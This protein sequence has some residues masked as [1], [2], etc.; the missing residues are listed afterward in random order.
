[1]YLTTSDILICFICF[2]LKRHR[3]FT[4]L[5]KLSVFLKYACFEQDE[6]AVFHVYLLRLLFL[7]L[8]S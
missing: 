6:S 7:V 5:K 4:Y 1:M 3:Y 8:K 2:T